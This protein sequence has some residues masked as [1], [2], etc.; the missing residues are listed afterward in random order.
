MSKRFSFD[1]GIFADILFFGLLGILLV[2]LQTTLIPRVSIFDASP[3][4]ILGAIAF[5]GICRDEKIASIFGLTM[6]L[7][8][9]A[10]TTT[11]LS[12]LPLFYCILGFVCGQIGKASKNNTRFAAFLVTI[13]ALSLSRVFVTF[14]YALIDY[15]SKID[16]IRFLTH[17]ALPEFVSNLVICI[18]VFF[19]TGL[20]N[21]PVKSFGNRGGQY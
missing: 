10:L 4:I 20:F 11:G 2:I 19:I 18:P 17:T 14:L 8:V 7:C 15:N 12:F 13:P 1:I 16:Y 21:L 5:L 9:D 6:G 3:D